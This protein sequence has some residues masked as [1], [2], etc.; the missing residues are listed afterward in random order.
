MNTGIH[1]IWFHITEKGSIY[2]IMEDIE[3]TSVY[4]VTPLKK[5]IKRGKIRKAIKGKNF[6]LFAFH[7]WVEDWN[8]KELKI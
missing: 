5:P 4:I 1:K 2:F 6:N 7:V 3:V 8:F